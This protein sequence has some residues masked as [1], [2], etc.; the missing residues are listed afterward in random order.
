[1][2][3]DSA[4]GNLAA[5]V[6]ML[7]RDRGG[8]KIIHQLLLY[9]V[10][11]CN[12]DTASYRDNGDGYFLT[13]DL[14]EHFQRLYLADG[15]DPTDWRASPLRATDLA[16]LPPAHVVTAEFDPLRDEGE[17][18]AARLDR[19]RRHGH[20]RPL[21]RPDPRLRRQPGRCHGRG[22]P[23]RRGRRPAPPD[24]LPAGLDAPP[25]G[26]GGLTL[27]ERSPATTSGQISGSAS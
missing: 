18:F 16:G 25:L 10:T 13:A 6:A 3:G 19:S 22:T 12:R 11:D 14:M 21:R 7:A 5:V 2:G 20:R 9:P 4:G 26:Q 27:Y 24:R 8:P 1:M 17:A 23:R 15:G